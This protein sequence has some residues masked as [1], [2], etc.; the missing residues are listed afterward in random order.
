MAK[1]SV[2]VGEVYQ[3]N[4]CGPYRITSYIDTKNVHIE[5]INTGTKTVVEGR[6]IKRGR[7][8]D[9]MC[10]SVLGVG[11]HGVGEF[12]SSYYCTEKK[13]YVK[14]PVYV[15]WTSMLTRCYSRATQLRQPTYIGCDVCPEWRCYQHFF[16]SVRN[17]EGF[18]KWSDYHMGLSDVCME[19]DKDKKSESGTGKLYS[20]ETC[21][22]ISSA[23]NIMIAA[24]AKFNATKEV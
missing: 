12:P 14:H 3:S 7:I 24:I 10:P 22:F 15:I 20:P 16:L 1:Q 21:C 6:E 4:K 8:K 13:K 19:L 11:Y 9:P 2:F 18:E 17:L 23:E 5:F